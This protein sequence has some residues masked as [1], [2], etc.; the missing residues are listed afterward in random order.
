MFLIA[1]CNGVD[2]SF[3]VYKFISAPNANKYLTAEYDP[4]TQAQC[5][6][7]QPLP[8]FVSISKYSFEYRKFKT[9]G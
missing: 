4:D 5:N 9:F 6:G 2:E 7:E 1:R 8:S 3:S